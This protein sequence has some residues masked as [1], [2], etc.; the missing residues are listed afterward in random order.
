MKVVILCGGFGK[1]I[2][3]ESVQK[4][5]PMVEIG[6]KPILWH[7]MKHYSHYKFDDFIICLGYKGYVIKDYFI[8]YA[9]YNNDCIL[10]MLDES[11]VGF[12]SEYIPWKIYFTDTGLHTGTAGRIEKI[13]TWLGKTFMMTYGDGVSD[14][15]IQKLVEFHKSHGKYATMLGA[16]VPSKFGSIKTNED[17]LVEEFHEKPV[18]SNSFINA[19]FFVL[20]PEVI[21][22]IKG[23]KDSWEYDILPKLVKDKQLMAYRYE[24]FFKC[25]DSLKD[26]NELREMWDSNKAPWKIW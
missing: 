2:W 15:N 19:G 11:I 23:N 6:R 12:S 21:D 14:V 16:I 3:E 20:E 17:G 8:N 22:Y 25:M 5:K 18:S 9:L 1:R 26:R 4:P 13:R 7:I 10:N 24:G